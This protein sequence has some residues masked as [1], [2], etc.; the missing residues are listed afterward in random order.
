MRLHWPGAFLATGKEASRHGTFP[1]ALNTLRPGRLR[2]YS[3]QEEV[4][5]LLS[6]LYIESIEEVE[7]EPPVM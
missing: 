2:H 7:Q 5:D 3:D 1:I 4:R 6:R